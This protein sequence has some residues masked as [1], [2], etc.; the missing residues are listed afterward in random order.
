MQ[1]RDVIGIRR[2]TL[3]TP[4]ETGEAMARVAEQMDGPFNPFGSKPLIGMAHGRSASFRRRLTFRNSFQ[5]QM[6]AEFEPLGTTTAI[7]L[8]SHMHWFAMIFM[9]FWVASTLVGGAGLTV[10]AAG[11]GPEDRLAPTFALL[12]FGMLAF[13]IGRAHV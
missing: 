11:S 12:P 8:R 4:L 2:A 10:Y 5:T 13:E 7:R 3:R 1:L 9:G 6:T